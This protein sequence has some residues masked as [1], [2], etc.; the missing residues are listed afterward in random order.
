MSDPKLESAMKFRELEQREANRRKE[1][2]KEL[3]ASLIE[4]IEGLEVIYESKK[5]RLYFAPN[6]DPMKA[7]KNGFRL[8][9]RQALSD[10][11][12]LIQGKE[13]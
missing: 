10:V 3:K 4:Q 11:I 5:S 7:H 2:A 9:A 13:E 12:N 1:I 6:S 8:G